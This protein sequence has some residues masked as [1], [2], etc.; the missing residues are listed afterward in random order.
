MGESSKPTYISVLEQSVMDGKK[1]MT[2]KLFSRVNDKVEKFRG[3]ENQDG[4]FSM[5][6]A[7][8]NDKSNKTLKNVSDFLKEIKNV[9]AL[10]FVH[11]YMSGRKKSLMSRESPMYS[12]ILE[13]TVMDG[14]RG[15][16]FKLFSRINDKT[17]KFV[18]KETEDGKID[19]YIVSDGKK[20]SKTLSVAE[21]L[22]EIK[23][24]PE[25]SFVSDYI[26]KR[27]KRTQSREMSRPKKSSKK[28]SKK[29]YKKS[30]KK[31]SKK[32]SKKA[33][34]KKSKK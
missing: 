6:V 5:S 31:A 7:V 14:S 34:K 13:K 22:K 23:K 11:K 30:S 26:S 3:A 8:G 21:L 9:K 24:T 19:M 15:M 1:G 25:L 10:D 12:S 18:G 32:S 29:S 28:A 17:E 27:K 16:S 4:S 2:F 20:D 33:S